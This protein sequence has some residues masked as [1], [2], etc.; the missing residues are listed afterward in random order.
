VAEPETHQNVQGD[1]DPRL[2]TSTPLKPANAVAAIILIGNN[3]L[4]QQ[5]DNKRGIFF[6]AHWGCFGGAMENGETHKEALVRELHEELA[7]ELQCAALRYFTR[8]RF[9]LSFAGLAPISRYYYEL[10]FAT[11]QL[12]TL[13]LQE[14]AAFRLFS[15]GQILATAVPLTPYDAFALWFHINRQRLTA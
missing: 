15:P 13:R 14:G 11:S 3:Y 4:L 7:I 10:E 6:P 1:G 5:R 8:F 2:D 9:D 12:A